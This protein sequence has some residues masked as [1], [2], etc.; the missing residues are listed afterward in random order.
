MY[1]LRNRFLGRDRGCDT[2]FE[3]FKWCE[4]VDMSSGAL[5]RASGVYVLKIIEKVEDIEKSSETLLALAER[6][7]WPESL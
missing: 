6:T 2:L 4:L 5:P 3:S 1:C 7:G